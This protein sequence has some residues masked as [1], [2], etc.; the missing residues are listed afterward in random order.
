MKLISRDVRGEPKQP[1]AVL[2]S[3]CF[4]IANQPYQKS[5]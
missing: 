2:F 5:H 3:Y 4:Q 1:F